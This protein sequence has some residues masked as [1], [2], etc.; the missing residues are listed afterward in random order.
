MKELPLTRGMVALIDDADYEKVCGFKYRI[1]KS[2][3][4]PFYAIRNT[5]RSL[6]PRRGIYLHQDLLPVPAGF[7]VHHIN[8]D[9]LDC[10]RKNLEKRTPAQNIQGR[11]KKRPNCTSRY[12]GVRQA[13][14]GR[15]EAALQPTNAYFHLGRYDTEEEAARAYD[16]KAT[17]VFGRFAS[18]NFP[19]VQ[20]P[21]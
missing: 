19:P 16:R 10:Q 20:N 5:S 11:Q 1:S 21:A 13:K 15:W 4:G 6:G 12:R 7:E 17:E 8:G 9:G 18:L 14:S 3:G 2:P